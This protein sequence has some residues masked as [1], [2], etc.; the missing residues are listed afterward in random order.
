MEVSAVPLT[1]GG[2]QIPETRYA[3]AGG[4]SI[5]YQVYGS[6]DRR[7][8]GVPG[9]ISNVELSWE[10]PPIHHYFERLGSFATIAQFDKRGTGCSDRIDRAA[11]LEDRMEDFHVV[12]DAVGW[13]SAS[14]FGLS[15]G[16]PLA[17]LFAATYPERTESLI[18]VGSSARFLWAPDYDIGLDP[19]DFE[20]FNQAWSARWG[21]PETLTV[22]IFSPSQLGD[23]AY[24]R[25]LTRFERLSSTP[26]NLLAMMQLNAQIDVRHVLPVI[27]VPTL[28][29]HAAQDLAVPVSHGRYLA[30]HIPKA[31]I[32][33]YDGEHFPTT[34]GVD[35]STA[36][37]ERF[38]TGTTQISAG[39]SVLSTV[40]FTDICGSSER[41]SALG[42]APWRALL[43]RHDEVLNEALLRHGGR[44]VTGTGDGL[45]A[46]VDSPTRALRCAIDMVEAAERIGLKIR[47]GVHTGEAERRGDDLAGIAVHIGARVAAEASPGEVLVSSAIPPL[48][49]GSQFRFSERGDYHLK[50]IPG[51][52]QLLA[53]EYP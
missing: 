40:I 51:T 1:R 25:Y 19:S 48:V 12:M 28:V 3:K 4:T 35:Q 43:D 47:V 26:D 2:M 7:I 46:A 18:L 13:E 42:D 31:Q 34:T 23:E 5:A 24:L 16:G 10:Y 20:A 45:L 6:G 8:V 36:A 52:W 37:I 22:R 41:A 33:E 39:D 49:V 15:E 44:R 14:I 29:V 32:T 21:T 38:L 50:G 53:V 27:N 17:C 30:A 11:S 9:V